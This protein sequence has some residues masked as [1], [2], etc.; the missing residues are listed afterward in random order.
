MKDQDKSAE[1]AVLEDKILYLTERLDQAKTAVQQWIDANASLARSA[2]EARAKNQGTG[3]GFLSGL[4]GSKFR[5]AMRQAAATSNASIS[6]E[7]AEKRTKIADGKREAQD[8]VRDLK[9]QLV[10]AKSELKLLIAEVKGS[11]RSKA[12]ITKVA[13][14][15]IE[16]M[17]KL[18]EAHSAGLLTD[19]E[20]E[21]KRKKLV[22]EL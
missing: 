17:Q 12:N 1:I 15:T 14:S 11:A 13:T 8:L 7:V 10:E 2:A 21:E 9:E 18:K 6:Q 19:A 4:L 22:S 5:G 20:Y 16:L 3:R